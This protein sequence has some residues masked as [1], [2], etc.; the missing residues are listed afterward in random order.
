MSG[1]YANKRDANEK[2]IVQE[3]EA[4]GYSVTKMDKP[5]DL[6]IGKHGRTWC[7]EVK[8][9]GGKLTKSQVDFY[10]AWRGNHLILRSIQ[11]AA[12]WAVQIEKETR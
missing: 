9:E 2:E 6:L 1:R 8:M 7:A 3:L 5:V 12:E 10:A 11:D 4:R